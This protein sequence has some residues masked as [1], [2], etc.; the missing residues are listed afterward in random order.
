MILE[1]PEYFEEF[2]CIGGACP[3]TC[4][5]GWE[6]DIDPDTAEYYRQVRGEI[7]KRLRAAM[8]DEGEGPYF[9]LCADGRCPFLNRENLCDIYSALGEESLSRVCT[10][11]PRYYNG[12]GDYEQVDL[13]LS[14][15][16]LG[17]IFFGLKGPIRYVRREDEESKGEFSQAESEGLSELLG[18]RNEA[19][20]ILQENGLPGTFREFSARFHRAGDLYGV[21][22]PETDGELLGKM[23]ELEVLD[24]RWEN[25]FSGIL[26]AEKS[27][28]LEGLAERFFTVNLK[29][30][31]SWFAKL[32]V[33]LIFRY[34][35]DAAGTGDLAAEWRFIRRSIRFLLLMCA[36][37]VAEKGGKALSVEDMVDISHIYS[38]QVEH[39]E[40]NVE[41]LRV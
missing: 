10:E 36:L 29:E 16:E 3:D 18:V 13:S 24:D 37:K 9:P 32:S 35:I 7:G 26:E 34:T 41:A 4:C 5:A 28:K 19:I 38:R 15:M 11:Y 22:P 14:C 6:V 39:S 27:G 33:Y 30:A 20:L 12:A 31:G 23:R 8:K 25:I 40:E 17:R 1:Y 2:H 21:L